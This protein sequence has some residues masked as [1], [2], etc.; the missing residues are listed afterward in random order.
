MI[1][2]AASEIGAQPWVLRVSYRDGF[3]RGSLELDLGARVGY[4]GEGEAAASRSLTSRE[5]FRSW[6]E[7]AVYI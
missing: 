5:C 7:F 3:L 4:L 1:H 6:L 2:A